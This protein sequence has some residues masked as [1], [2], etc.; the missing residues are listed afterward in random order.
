MITFVSAR[1]GRVSIAL[2][3][4]V[5]LAAAAAAPLFTAAV[6]AHEYKL[7]DPVW[8]YLGRAKRFM[9]EQENGKAMQL[10]HEVIAAETNN[11]DAHF[12]LGVL[13]AGENLPDQAIRHFNA[14]I[15]YSSRLTVPAQEVEARFMILR[16]TGEKNSKIEDKDISDIIALAKR[17]K[18]P[19]LEGR[20]YFMLAEYY[21]K[22]SNE[23]QAEIYY[24]QAYAKEYERKLCQYRCSLIARAKKDAAQEKRFLIRATEYS[25]DHPSRENDRIEM[26]I[27]KRLDELKSVSISRR[28][29]PKAK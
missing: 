26:L 12:L 16:I 20:L 3:A 29:L 4:A 11:A 9:A 8:V 2:A 14:V 18:D 19:Y 15:K 6:P 10:L 17:R 5:F 24:D 28:S 27:Q 1:T 22:F 13:N 23:V 7:T 21:E 25:F